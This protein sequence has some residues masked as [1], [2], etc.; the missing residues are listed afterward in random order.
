MAVKLNKQLILRLYSLAQQGRRSIDFGL[1]SARQWT[2]LREYYNDDRL[3]PIHHLLI[4]LETLVRVPSQPCSRDQLA[5]FRP[6]WVL[7]Y[8]VRVLLN[9]WRK[10]W[11]FPTNEVVFFVTVL[12]RFLRT[13]SCKDQPANP[14]L[15]DLRMDLTDCQWL[16]DRRLTGVAALNEALRIEHFCQSDYLQFLTFSEVMELAAR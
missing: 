8:P 13:L 3:R 2:L 5:D 16:I 11:L 10:S 1:S 14:M 12:S 7:S 4:E 9:R 15:V 6:S